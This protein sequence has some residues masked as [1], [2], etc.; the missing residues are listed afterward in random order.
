[1]ISY[2]LKI[3]ENNECGINTAISIASVSGFKL[4]CR[5]DIQVFSKLVENIISNFKTHKY[6]INQ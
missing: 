4:V 3:I 2:S 6:S 1:M 5:Q